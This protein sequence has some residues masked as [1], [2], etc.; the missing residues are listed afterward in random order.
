MYCWRS[1]Y[2]GVEHVLSKGYELLLLNGMSSRRHA[3]YGPMGSPARPGPIFL[4]FTSILREGRKKK[5]RWW[6]W[7]LLTTKR[8]I[9]QIYTKQWDLGHV[10]LVHSSMITQM[11]WHVLSARQRENL[12]P[13]L[14]V[15]PI[16]TM[17]IRFQPV[18]SRTINLPIS[19]PKREIEPSYHPIHLPFCHK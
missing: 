13:V 16:M 8:I 14:L 6:Q 11:V 2:V 12:K 3:I 19:L 7:P 17:M 18:L 1:W 5:M 9:F 10:M 4:N 15:L